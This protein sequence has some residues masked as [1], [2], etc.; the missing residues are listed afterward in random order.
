MIVGWDAY[1]VPHWA[2]GH[3]DYFVAVS[4]DGFV[5][6]EIRTPEMHDNAMKILSDH[7]WIRLLMKS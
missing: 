7:D 6:I 2:Y 1:Y 5:D 4:H 3:L